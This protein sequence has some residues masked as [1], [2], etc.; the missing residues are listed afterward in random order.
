MNITLTILCCIDNVLLILMDKVNYSIPDFLS[1]F[2]SM[3]PSAKM[4]KLNI[5]TDA[6]IMYFIISLNIIISLDVSFQS[7]NF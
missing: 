3:C 6:N 7:A 1:F 4:F 2:A 5:I